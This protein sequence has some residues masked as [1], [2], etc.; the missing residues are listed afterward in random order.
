MVRNIAPYTIIDYFSAISV[1]SVADVKQCSPCEIGAASISPGKSVSQ[2]PMTLHIGCRANY[3]VSFRRQ[4][5][6]P[7]L[8]VGRQKRG[9][10]IFEFLCVV[11]VL[12]GEKSVVISLP[13]SS[14]RTGRSCRRCNRTLLAAG[15]ARV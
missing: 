12:R 3:F 14:G 11:C 10:N 13:A 15:L 1:F 4:K 5:K 7:R 6:P 2:E 8:P 9:L